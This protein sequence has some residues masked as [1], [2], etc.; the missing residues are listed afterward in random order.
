MECECVVPASTAL[1]H[2]TKTHQ[3][4]HLQVDKHHLN[5]II[6]QENIVSLWPSLPESTV[7]AFKGLSTKYG[8]LC[9]TCGDMFSTPKS[10]L[11]H[12]RDKHQ[13]SASAAELKCGWMQHF[14]QKPG[15]RSWFHVYPFPANT[16]TAPPDYL[17]NLRQQLDRSPPLAANEL[18][19]RHINPWLITTGWL[20][21]A[22]Q[23][24]S[25]TTPALINIPPRTSIDPHCLVKDFVH[26][27]LDGAYLLIPRTSEICRQILHTDTI[28]EYVYY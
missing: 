18:D 23:Y 13:V 20:E 2:I 19:I 24:P 26:R 15:G 11:P 22:Q 10:T 9:P 8:Y 7:P 25:Y 17:V 6:S 21:Y 12:S 14:S 3:S 28:T 5:T 16:F 4:A 27:Y 1:N